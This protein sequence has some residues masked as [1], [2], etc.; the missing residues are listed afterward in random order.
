M[1]RYTNPHLLSFVDRHMPNHAA[2]ALH[3]QNCVDTMHFCTFF[4]NLQVDLDAILHFLLDSDAK[5]T[6][7][8]C[9]IFYYYYY[10]CIFSS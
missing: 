9:F 2:D 1:M 3:V 4:E 7:L 6:I 10:C 8:K 5:L